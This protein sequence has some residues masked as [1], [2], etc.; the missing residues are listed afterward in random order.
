MP[1]YEYRCQTC[2]AILEFLVRSGKEPT[3]CGDS[4]TAASGSQ[5]G[6]GKLSKIISKPADVKR[7]ERIGRGLSDKE[8]EKAGFT[9]LKKESGGYRRTAGTGA[10]EWI[11]KN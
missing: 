11:P 10:P 8:V 3:V 7:P 4:C 1:I 2:G 9:R 5:R 6:K